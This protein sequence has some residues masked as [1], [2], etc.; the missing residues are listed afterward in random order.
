[1]S[2]SALRV[3]I[4]CLVFVAFTSPRRRRKCRSRPKTEAPP[5]RMVR[6]CV[7]ASTATVLH[8]TAHLDDEDGA[9]LAWLSRQQGVRTVVDAHLGRGRRQPDWAR[10]VR[11]AWHSTYRRAAGCGALL[12]R[13][14]DVY[15]RDRILAFPNG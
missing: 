3:L 12:R 9:L 13:G 8:T 5:P 10:A 2:T 15:A 6:C 14:P 4:C 7:C 1:M 11:R